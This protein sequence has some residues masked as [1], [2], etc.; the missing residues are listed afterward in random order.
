[1]KMFPTALP[2]E[3]CKTAILERIITL[4]ILVQGNLDF[5]NESGTIA[6]GVCVVKRN[7]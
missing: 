2:Q 6:T 4:D 1:M 3:L 5:L 7:G